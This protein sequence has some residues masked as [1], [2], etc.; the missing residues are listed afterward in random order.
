MTTDQPAMTIDIIEKMGARILSLDD[1]RVTA[2]MPLAPN[3]NHVGTMYAGSLFTLAEFPAGALFVRRVDTRK[4][5]PIVA[6]VKIRFRRPALT[7][8]FMSLEIA[9]A[10][11]ERLQRETLAEGKSSLINHQELTDT[12]GEVVAIAEARYVWLKAP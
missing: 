11:F 6:E 2:T 10:E 12:N 7:D 9:E 3:V 5:L 8:V 1:N 4:I